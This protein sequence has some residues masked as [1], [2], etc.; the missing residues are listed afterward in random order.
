MCE[1]IGFT[2]IFFTN[3]DHVQIVGGWPS[4]RILTIKAQ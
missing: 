1:G 4:N 3:D 2:N